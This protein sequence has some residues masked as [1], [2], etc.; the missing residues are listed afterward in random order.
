[1]QP[2]P[3]KKKPKHLSYT[4]LYVFSKNPPKENNRQIGENP[5]NL[6]TLA[7]SHLAFNYLSIFV[8]HSGIF[9]IKFLHL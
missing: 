3:G 4:L 6:V 7:S 2:L 9:Y 5:L 8:K 1:M